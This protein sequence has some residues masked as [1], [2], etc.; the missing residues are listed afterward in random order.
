MVATNND[1]VPLWDKAKSKC[2]IM[3]LLI[4]KL[5]LDRA[6]SLDTNFLL[7]TSKHTLVVP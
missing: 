7:N 4:Q 3:S 6:G 5:T 1:I 2:F